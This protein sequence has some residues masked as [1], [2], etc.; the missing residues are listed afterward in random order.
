MFNVPANRPPVVT[1]FP[2]VI[3]PTA[4]TTPL[5]TKLEAVILPLLFKLV[6]VP[7]LVILGCAAVVTVPARNASSALTACVA[8]ATGP[9]ILLPVI[10]LK[11]PASPKN[12]GDVI[13]PVATIL[14][15]VVK[16]SLLVLSYVGTTLPSTDRLPPEPPV[17]LI[18]I[19]SKYNVVPLRYKSRH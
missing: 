8:F 14:A 13:V 12:A 10:L 16:S 1:K 5:V 9:V 3:L 7:T 18:G 4:V 19:P 17:Y 11:L 6:N 2:P 15:G